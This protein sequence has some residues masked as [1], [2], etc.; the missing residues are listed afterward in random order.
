MGIFGSKKVI[1][2]CCKKEDLTLWKEVCQ[3]CF[4][5]H[6]GLNRP[7]QSQVM[8]KMDKKD[9]ETIQELIKNQK[10]QPDVSDYKVLS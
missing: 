6:F 2:D 9:L 3:D 4:D 7:I 8:D 5:K 10:P 1:C